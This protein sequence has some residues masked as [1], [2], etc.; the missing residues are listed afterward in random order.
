M[1]LTLAVR[2]ALGWLTLT[3]LYLGGWALFAPRSFYDGFPGLGR[4]WVSIDGPYNEHLVRDVGALNLALAALSLAAAVRLSRELVTV[5]AVASLLWGVP[6]L[7]YHAVN[8][9][10][11]SGTDVALNLGGLIAA[12]VVSLLLLRSASLLERVEQAVR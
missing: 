11:F 2:L 5:A 9:D 8:T 7:G 12:V 4:S 3:A 6:H 10:G 1:R